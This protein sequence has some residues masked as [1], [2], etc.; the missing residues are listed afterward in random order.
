MGYY[1]Q[2][3]PEQT[4]NKADFLCNEYEGIIITFE[5]AKALINNPEIAI[6]CVVDNGL[7]EAAA[8]CYSYKEFEDFSRAEDQRPKV[9]LLFNNA[10]KIREVA[11]Y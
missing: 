11:G 2:A 7:F 9:W 4:H 10:D 6:V 5:E 3:P 8:Y 1:L